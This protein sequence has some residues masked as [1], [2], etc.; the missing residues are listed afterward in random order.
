MWYVYIIY[1]EIIHKYYTGATDGL[2][3]RLQRHNQGWGRYTKGGIPWK[4]VYTEK[5]KTKSEALKRE[6]DIKRRKSRKYI[7]G[8]IKNK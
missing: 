7:E 2:E 6:R 1:S 5:F 8:L 3:W 4:I